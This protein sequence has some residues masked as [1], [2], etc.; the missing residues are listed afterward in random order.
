M[1]TTLCDFALRRQL[2]FCGNRRTKILIETLLQSMSALSCLFSFLPLTYVLKQSSLSSLRLEDAA[3]PGF[4]CLNIAAP[5]CLKLPAPVRCIL[6]FFLL[7]SFQ[8]LSVAGQSA[9]TRKATVRGHSTQS[10]VYEVYRPVNALEYF[11]SGGLT[12]RT[13][14]SRFRSPANWGDTVWRSSRLKCILGVRAELEQDS[15]L[16]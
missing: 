7:A 14:A 2:L 5:F 6:S 13:L 3:H 12:V 8:S 11:S 4:D 1:R 10:C 9:P 15:H 16:A